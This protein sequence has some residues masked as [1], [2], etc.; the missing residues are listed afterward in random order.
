MSKPTFTTQFNRNAEKTMKISTVKFEKPSMVKKSLAYATD[1]NTIYDNYCRT[2][3]LPL[4]GNQPIYDSN[5]IAINTLVEA[6]QRV[7]EAT[8]YFQNLPSDIRSQY[9]N[10]LEK[11]VNAVHSQDNFLVEKGVL[12]LKD[13]TIV[14][15]SNIPVGPTT[16][17]QTVI[18]TPTQPTVE[19]PSV[20]P[21]TTV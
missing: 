15:D 21:A 13:E 14:P 3:R 16:G 20:A 4:N 8:E 18:D 11:F 9:G 19:T 17:S 2:G 5:F 7:K 10:S 12:K 6:Q 1:I